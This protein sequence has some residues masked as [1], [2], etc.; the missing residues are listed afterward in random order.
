MVVSPSPVTRQNLHCVGVDKS[1]CFTAHEAIWFTANEDEGGWR[2]VVFVQVS[3]YEN[4]DIYKTIP[5][6]GMQHSHYF[7]RSHVVEETGLYPL[8]QTVLYNREEAWCLYH[9]KF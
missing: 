1:I 5:G 4:Y 9:S 6:T 2:P 8:D 3:Y 7:D